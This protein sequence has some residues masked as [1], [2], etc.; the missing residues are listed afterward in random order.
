MQ[1]Q[2]LISILFFSLIPII[3]FILTKLLKPTPQPRSPPLPGPSHLPL[4]GNLHHLLGQPTHHALRRLATIHGP[5]MA[6]RLGRLNLIIISSPEAA[7]AIMK[8]HDLNFSD[9]PLTPGGK[10]VLYSGA[11]LA[12]APYGPRWRQHRR[13][14][15]LELLSS[16]RVRSF[17]SISQEEVSN[18]LSRV[19]SLSKLKT[20][21]NLTREFLS[22]SNA[23]TSRAAFGKKCRHRDKFIGGVKEFFHMG[24]TANFAEMFPPFLCV[25]VITGVRRRL[26]RIRR[27]FDEILDEII[28]DHEVRR[29]KQGDEV[30]G[31]DEDFVDV[32]LRIRDE[33]GLDVPLTDVHVKALILDMFIGG[34]ETSAVVLEWAMSELVKNPEIM[35]KAQEEARKVLKGC[36]YKMEEEDINKLKYLM[37]VIKETLRL[38]PPLPLLVPRVNMEECKVLD[39]VIPKGSRV[40]INYWAMSRDPKIWEDAESF[41]PERFEGSSVDFK[42]GNFEYIPFGAGRRMCPGITFG[43]ANVLLLLA[44][45]LCYFDWELPGG[46]Q[47][48]D[49]DMTELFGVTMGRKTSLSLIATPYD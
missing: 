34:T 2:I 14:C 28:M 49:L 27:L 24:L 20:P 7:K 16:R 36:K 3:L 18:L 39:Y 21:V 44:H 40:I 19:S 45:L 22:F 6:L 9:R 47:G 17:S 15:T 43:L 31:E 29:Y 25:D 5:I 12:F 10:T 42:G 30:D 48:Q 37:L 41:R 33:G 46:G 1:L 35:K 26:R 8:T 38:H 4:I 32:L 23:V 11:G 13:I